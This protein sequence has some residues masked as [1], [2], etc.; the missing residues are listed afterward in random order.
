MKIFGINFDNQVDFTNQLSDRAVQWLVSN[1]NQI[2]TELITFIEPG[3]SIM[4]SF[5][6]FE[7][8]IDGEFNNEPR[9]GIV[10]GEGRGH[11]YILAE[12]LQNVI[13]SYP[14]GIT[15]AKSLARAFHKNGYKIKK[16][17]YIRYR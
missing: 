13:R 1:A 11:V 10:F 6:C 7:L 4:P 16:V 14:S 17:G 15:D 5:A 8:Y 2:Q 9:L 3:V 12:A